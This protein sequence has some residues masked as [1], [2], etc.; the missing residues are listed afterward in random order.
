MSK[1]YKLMLA[2]V[3]FMATGFLAAS[4]AVADEPVAADSATKLRIGLSQ[5][6]QLLQ[7]MDTDK[8]G[9]VSKGEFMRFMEAEFDF[10]DTNKNGELD[11]K[12]LQHL[13]YRF[14]HPVKGP[15]R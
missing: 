5:T 2:G 10:A 12:E 14:S 4:A 6:A 3:V 8:N 7:L 9:K 15:G 13:I 1:D 11:P